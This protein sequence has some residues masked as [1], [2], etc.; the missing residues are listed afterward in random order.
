MVRK[1]SQPWFPSSRATLNPFEVLYDKFLAW[2]LWA[3]KSLKLYANIFGYF[4]IHI[5]EGRG[6]TAFLT[7]SKES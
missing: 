6:Y 1:S 7:F 4:H 5:L 3:F 2:D